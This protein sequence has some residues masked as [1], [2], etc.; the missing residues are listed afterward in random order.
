MKVLLYYKKV[1]SVSL[2]GR[3]VRLQKSIVLPLK[4]KD[5]PQ[6]SGYGLH[7]TIREPFV[8]SF[9]IREKRL[10]LSLEPGQH[11]VRHPPVLHRSSI[12]A[13]AYT[14]CV[15]NQQCLYRWQGPFSTLEL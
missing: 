1:T 14:A 8:S 13:L 12:F 10:E 7:V 2:G 5:A 4:T 11:V 3:T 6:C 15:H 9:N